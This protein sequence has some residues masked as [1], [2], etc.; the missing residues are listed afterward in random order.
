MFNFHHSDWDLLFFCEK[1]KIPLPYFVKRIQVQIS[2]VLFILLN[3]YVAVQPG[4][5][6]YTGTFRFKD[7]NDALIFLCSFVSSAFFRYFVYLSLNRSKRKTKQNEKKKTLFFFKRCKRKRC[8]KKGFSFL[9][10]CYLFGHTPHILTHSVQQHKVHACSLV[11]W[12]KIFKEN[13]DIYKVYEFSIYCIPCLDI[14]CDNKN[15]EKKTERRQ[16]KTKVYIIKKKSC[17]HVALVT[18]ITS[19]LAHLIIL[20]LGS[21]SF[22][23]R[24]TNAELTSLNQRIFPYFSMHSLYCT[25]RKKYKRNEHI[26]LT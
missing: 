26:N 21:I 14:V 25:S 5:I 11:K 9:R 1:L 3:T 19:F 13:K 24:L 10:R 16:N 4:C 12:K 20:E 22:M 6:F 15:E 7:F 17:I 18:Q 23:M 2:S 8:W